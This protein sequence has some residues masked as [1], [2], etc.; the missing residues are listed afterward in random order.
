MERW[1]GREVRLSSRWSTS[2]RDNTGR[3]SGRRS[4]STG[5]EACRRDSSRRG[6]QCTICAQDKGHAGVAS[7][8]EEWQFIVRTRTQHFVGIRTDL[9]NVPPFK[10]PW[11]G[12]GPGSRAWLHKLEQRLEEAHFMRVNSCDAEAC[13][14]ARRKAK[15]LMLKRDQLEWAGFR[16]VTPGS[17]PSRLRTGD[18]TGPVRTAD[19]SAAGPAAELRSGESGLGRSRSRHRCT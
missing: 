8:D 11:H 4:V 14:R 6:Y 19:V 12:R 7:N 10:A 3:T 1:P 2:R 15:S 5:G 13:E 18:S 17:Y 9:P 16:E